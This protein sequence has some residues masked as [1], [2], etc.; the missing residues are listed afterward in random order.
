MLLRNEI[1]MPVRSMTDAKPNCVGVAPERRNRAK[2][3]VVVPGRFKEFFMPL[4][5]LGILFAVPL[6]D[7]YATLRLAEALGVPG[8][9]MFIPGM[10]AGALLMKRETQTLKSRFVGAVQTMGVHGM[11]FDSGRRMLAAV[12]LLLPGFISDL[13][14]I[15]LL[16]MPNRSLIAAS[17]AANTGAAH[18]GASSSSASAAKTGNGNTNANATVVDGEFRRVE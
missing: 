4:I 10:I 2:V 12:L 13:F 5:L 14:A 8:L 15:F 7:I 9:A 6:L 3:K 1:A 17:A 11:V 18:N 16:L